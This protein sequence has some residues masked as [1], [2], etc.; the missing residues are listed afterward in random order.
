M[1]SRCRHSLGGYGE[2]STTTWARALIPV[3][4]GVAGLLAVAS[5]TGGIGLL[6]PGHLIGLVPAVLAPLA[7]AAVIAALRASSLRLPHQHAG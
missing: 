7:L 1:L 2:D 6:V 4:V 3:F 5:L